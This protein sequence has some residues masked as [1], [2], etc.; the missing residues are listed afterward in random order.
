[1][2]AIA[3]LVESAFGA[4]NYLMCTPSI[5]APYAPGTGQHALVLSQLLVWSLGPG[6]PVSL[7]YIQ[8]YYNIIITVTCSC[9]LW[10]IKETCCRMPCFY[11]YLTLLN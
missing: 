1:M 2:G 6:D 4:K 5:N 8:Y 7:V 3:P 10:P 11:I 9:D